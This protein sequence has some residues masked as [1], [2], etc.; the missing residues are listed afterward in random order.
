MARR[1][2]LSGLTSGWGAVGEAGVQG[3]GGLF[4]VPPPA[5]R[6]SPLAAGLGLTAAVSHAGGCRPGTNSDARAGALRLTRM[7]AAAGPGPT[8]VLE[9]D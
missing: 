6:G 7:C 5:G 2:G 4:D 3:V 1:V 9:G 8:R